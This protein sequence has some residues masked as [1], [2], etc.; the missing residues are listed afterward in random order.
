[1]YQVFFRKDRDEETIVSNGEEIGADF[2]LVTGD[3]A[4]ITASLVPPAQAPPGF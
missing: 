2:D 1:L 4:D 3:T